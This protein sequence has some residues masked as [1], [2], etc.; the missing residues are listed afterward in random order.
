MIPGPGVPN[1]SPPWPDAVSYCFQFPSIF[2]YTPWD[3]FWTPGTPHGIPNLPRGFPKRCQNLPNPFQKT[4][5]TLG[6]QK[7]QENIKKIMQMDTSKPWKWCS[8]ADAVHISIKPTSHKNYLIIRGQP[9]QDVIKILPKSTQNRL[10]KELSKTRLRGRKLQRRGPQKGAS[11]GGKGSARDPKWI[12]GAPNKTRFL[13]IKPKDVPKAFPGTA[14]H[15]IYT[16]PGAT[17]LH[18]RWVFRGWPMTGNRK[19]LFV[20]GSVIG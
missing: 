17:W 7:W 6:R 12:T 11:A 3:S 9:F 13:G 5:Q 1:C 4:L 19:Y 10:V 16:S 18:F 14:Q 8:C 15:V 20:I 2:S